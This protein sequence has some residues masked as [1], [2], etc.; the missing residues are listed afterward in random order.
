MPSN[1]PPDFVLAMETGV[2]PDFPERGLYKQWDKA[3]NAIDYSETPNH[4]GQIQC[5]F[6][7]HWAPSL[8]FIANKIADPIKTT[9][10]PA[11]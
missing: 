3:W 4:T 9:E 11:V 2:M 8:C 1:L 5:R 6:P 10:P 7:P